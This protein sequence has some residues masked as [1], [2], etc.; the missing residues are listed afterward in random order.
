MEKA[1]ELLK[2]FLDKHNIAGGEDYLSFFQGWSGL[3]GDDLADHTDLV[4]VR[5]GSAIVEVDHPAYMQLLQMRQSR[6]LAAM[7]KKHPSLGLKR[8]DIRLVKRGNRA[9]V[10]SADPRPDNLQSSRPPAAASPDTEPRSET[11]EE[12]VEKLP[13][14]KL[15]SL[16][17]RLREDLEE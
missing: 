16:L 4:D 12:A 13:E 9:G 15:K 3:V 14:S 17:E 11:A 5:N 7:Q 10:R 1:S 2:R 6:I 8:I